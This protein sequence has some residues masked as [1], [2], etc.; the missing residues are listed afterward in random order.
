M[1]VIYPPPERISPEAKSHTLY[2][3]RDERLLVRIYNWQQALGYS[4]LIRY[5]DKNGV[6]RYIR[7]DGAT[8]EDYYVTNVYIELEEGY[9]TGVNVYSIYYP[10]ASYWPFFALIAITHGRTV[11]EE[12]STALA[13]GVA[14]F[15]TPLSWPPATTQALEDYVDAYSLSYGDVG[16][17]SWSWAPP[18]EVEIYY[19]YLTVALGSG[20]GTRLLTLKTVYGDAD[21]SG[22]S[23]P[24][25]VAGATYHVIVSHHIEPGIMGRTV[26]VNLPTLNHLRYMEN[27]EV[28]LGNA[29]T[30]DK[31]DKYAMRWI[32]LPWVRR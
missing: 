7:R 20:T 24:L 22:A 10:G 6:E 30:G 12:V 5:Y 15:S 28:T 29:L 19:I 21:T 2:V 25:D 17:T 8:H 23:V 3:S 32:R 11:I 4:V 16:A 31:I 13:Y 1:A 26:Y 18:G 9:I 27:V 14:G